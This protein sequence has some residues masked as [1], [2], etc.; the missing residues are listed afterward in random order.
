MNVVE[1]IISFEELE[2]ISKEKVVS[3]ALNSAKYRFA[4]RTGRQ[5]P[6]EVAETIRKI[7][8]TS[9]GL[10]GGVYIRFQ[11]QL[12]APGK[13]VQLKE[14]QRLDYVLSENQDQGKG[15]KTFKYLL[16]ISIINEVQ[17]WERLAKFTAT[18]VKALLPS[19]WREL[20]GG[21]ELGEGTIKLRFTPHPLRVYP[22]L[23][24]NRKL[25]SEEQLSQIK[26]GRFISQLPFGSFNVNGKELS[27]YVPGLRRE[28]NYVFKA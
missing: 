24:N 10:E 22:Q 27:V 3:G 13:C 6:D 28:E 1:N 26:A 15:K 23:R 21:L 7:L 9:G 12:D 8:M 11:K 2:K 25:G 16:C 18:R 14:S 20:L 4:E 5:L 17:P 19:E